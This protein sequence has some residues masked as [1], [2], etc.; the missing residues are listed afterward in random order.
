MQRASPKAEGRQ[1]NPQSPVSTLLQVCVSGRGVRGGVQEQPPSVTRQG[2][3]K[4][5]GSS[6]GTISIEDCPPSGSATTPI[7]RRPWAFLSGRVRWPRRTRSSSWPEERRGRGNQPWRRDTCF[8][9]A[10]IVVVAR[11]PGEDAVPIIPPGDLDRDLGCRL[12]DVEQRNLDT[13]VLTVRRL[14]GA[15]ASASARDEQ[16]GEEWRR[17]RS[18]QAFHQHIILRS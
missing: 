14:R 16:C 10:A 6:N 9:G 12:R 8:P 3:M 11:L 15:P 13:A 17:P 1:P 4:A 18:L 5:P 2:P 7:R